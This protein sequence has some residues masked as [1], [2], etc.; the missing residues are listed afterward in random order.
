[1]R[2]DIEKLMK[3][4]KDSSLAFA[5]GQRMNE[6]TIARKTKEVESLMR[7]KKCKGCILCLEDLKDRSCSDPNLISDL[8]ER[9]MTK[10]KRVDSLEEQIRKGNLLIN[11]VCQQNFQF[12]RVKTQDYYKSLDSVK[13]GYEQ[14]LMEVEERLTL[15]QKRCESLIKTRVAVLED[16]Y[17]KSKS[18]ESETAKKFKESQL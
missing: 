7:E 18:K 3:N 12:L 1:M 15:E 5:I 13:S 10:A 17:L 4:L 11:Q 6:E 9:L 14:R 2:L 16:K 8:N